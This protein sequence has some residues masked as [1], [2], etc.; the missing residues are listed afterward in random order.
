M[1]KSKGI[2]L[3]ALIITIIILLILS[4]VAIATLNGD[5]GLFTRARQAR[6][7]TLEGQERENSILQ[8]YNDIIDNSGI[9]EEEYTVSYKSNNGIGS[10]ESITAKK[11]TKIKLSNN[12]N[13]FEYAGNRLVGWIDQNNQEYSLNQEIK[14][15]ENMELTAKWQATEKTYIYKKGEGSLDD[16]AGSH[17][18]SK[19]KN[20]CVQ[21][22]RYRRTIDA[23]GHVVW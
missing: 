3:I 13:G 18:S 10:I 6:N 17:Y 21:N 5:N 19:R 23:S 22:R 12:E 7:N 1:K 15:L 11:G 16:F 20:F 4:G 9:E 8:E 14:I 2:T